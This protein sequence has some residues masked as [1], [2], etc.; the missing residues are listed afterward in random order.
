MKDVSTTAADTYRYLNF[1]KID[2]FVK[3]ADTVEFTEEYYPTLQK[4]LE[5]LKSA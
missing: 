2:E 1:D 5:R 3:A 4:E